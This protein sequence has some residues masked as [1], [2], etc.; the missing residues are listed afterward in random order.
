MRF[1]TSWRL[2]DSFD[3]SERPFPR[4]PS[5]A[6]TSTISRLPPKDVLGRP[7]TAAGC[8]T[9]VQVANNR[10]ELA[11]RSLR[12]LMSRPTFSDSPASGESGRSESVSE[13]SF[14]LPPKLCP[15]GAGSLFPTRY[16]LMSCRFRLRAFCT[17]PWLAEPLIHPPAGLYYPEQ[18]Y[19]PF[20]RAQDVLLPNLDVLLTLKQTGAAFAQPRP[21]QRLAYATG[22]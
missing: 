19:P 3:L 11:G 14:P 2:C 15:S 17:T 20:A 16:W 13:I 21:L 1:E 9:W 5:R 4:L 18:T 8:Y 6:L 22:D 7:T 12:S 10:R